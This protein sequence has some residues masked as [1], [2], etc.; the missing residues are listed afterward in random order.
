MTRKKTIIIISAIL[1]VVTLG[2]I[3]LF[4]TTSPAKKAVT[5]GTATTDPVSGEKVIKDSNLVQSNQ[6][7]SLPNQ[8]TILGLNK[9]VDYGLGA[10]QQASVGNALNIFSV[11]RDPKITQISLYQDSYTQKIN[12][13]TG[14]TT[15]TFKMQ[16]NKKTDYYVV[17][18]YTGSSTAVT[19]IYKADTT[20][21]LFTQ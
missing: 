8:P 14:E 7:S 3:G 17:V 16:A 5:Q 9:L 21:L 1:I 2:I 19:N 18:T 10:D 20:T 6:L 13:T 4:K 15:F 11:T 12:N